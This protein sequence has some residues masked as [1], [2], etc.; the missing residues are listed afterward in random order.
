MSD[1][2]YPTKPFLRPKEKALALILSL[3]MTGSGQ[4]YNDQIEKGVGM[5]LASIALLFAQYFFGWPWEHTYASQYGQWVLMVNIGLKIWSIIDAYLCAEGKNRIAKVDYDL[6]VKARER[7]VGKQIQEMEEERERYVNTSQLVESLNK[8]GN[9]FSNKILSR[10]EFESKKT[11]LLQL[12]KHKN[13]K[14][15]IEDFLVPLIPLYE[16][17]LLS[18]ED[19]DSIKATLGIKA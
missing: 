6:Y 15:E 7:K 9:L 5:L 8:Y 10:D 17:K 3:L 11:E 12:L 14:E 16:N 2:K 18:S 13:V 1:L 19:I 4:I